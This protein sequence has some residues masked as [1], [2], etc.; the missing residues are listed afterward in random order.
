MCKTL[1]GGAQPVE[2]ANRSFVRGLTRLCQR[3]SPC[4]NMFLGRLDCLLL[5]SR[6]TKSA[7][8]LFLGACGLCAMLF[9]AA[10]DR[11]PDI[12]APPEQRHPVEGYNPG[13][14]AMMVEMSCTTA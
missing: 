8:N 7:A 2:Y 5:I 14:D 11:P 1:S 9:L 4:H 3:R 12:F 13:P 6:K 10:C